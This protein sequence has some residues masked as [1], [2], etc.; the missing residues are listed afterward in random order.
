MKML[1]FFVLCLM[2]ALAARSWDV[3]DY[4]PCGEYYH[5]EA[6]PIN[7]YEDTEIIVDPYKKWEE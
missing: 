4:D 6:R 1:L 5:W 7:R 3:E 2:G